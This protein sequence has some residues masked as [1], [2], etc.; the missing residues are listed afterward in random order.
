MTTPIDPLRTDLPID[1]V[2]ERE[3]FLKGI[4]LFN[5]HDFFAAH[6]AWEDAWRP[7]QAGVRREFYQAMIQSAVALEHY[8]RSNPR[9]VLNLFNTSNRHF[10]AV[11]ASF[12]GI[13]LSA[14]REGMRSALRS[15]IEADPFPQRGQILLNVLLVPRIVLTSDPFADVD[16]ATRSG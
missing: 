2:Q 1:S 9:G 13:D 6:E 14:F 4:S 5:A 8:R 11:P 16:A 12:M 15:V 10:E 7:M 3:L